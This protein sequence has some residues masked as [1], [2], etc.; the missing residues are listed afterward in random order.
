MKKKNKKMKWVKLMRKLSERF[1]SIKLF[2]A[3]GLAI[4]IGIASIGITNTAVMALD[5]E[6][7]NTT[8]V[9]FGSVTFPLGNGTPF[10]VEVEFPSGWYVESLPESDQTQEQ[11]L[12]LCIG[13]GDKQFI[14]NEN[15]VCV[16]AIGYNMYEP[17][18][19][20]EN[21]P[22]AIFCEIGIAMGYSFDIYD[23]Y[24]SVKAFEQGETAV[25]DVRYSASFRSAWYEREAKVNKG[26]LSYSNDLKQYIAI[27]LESESTDVDALNK[28][29]ESIEWVSSNSQTSINEIIS[30]ILNRKIQ[31]RLDGE[32]RYTHDVNGTPTYPISY[33]GTTYLPI[34][35]ICDML[36]L[37]IEW[38]PDEYAVDIT[39][40]KKGEE[41]SLSVN[42]EGKIVLNAYYGDGGDVISR[43]ESKLSVKAHLT[44]C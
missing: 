29:A 42:D 37:N 35:G 18:Y 11:K 34:R 10:S 17:T 23:N 26:I 19:G 32:T 33:N 31:I 5:N 14:Y 12:Y 8:I 20:N 21:N 27:E 44:E 2:R 16:G 28:I 30:A 3:L 43:M 41:F 38:N 15:D 9:E 39:T 1:I 25:T 4:S 22:K 24:K 6:S 40:V 7:P 13:G 36:N